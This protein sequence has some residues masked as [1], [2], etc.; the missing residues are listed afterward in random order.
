LFVATFDSSLLDCIIFQLH[1]YAFSGGKIVILSPPNLK[2]HLPL[3]P[4]SKISLIMTH[5]PNTNQPRPLL[6]VRVTLP[7]RAT[8]KNRQR[9]RLV[10]IPRRAGLVA[11][12]TRQ[13]RLP[14]P[15]RVLGI[16]R[17][18]AMG[19]STPRLQAPPPHIKRAVPNPRMRGMHLSTTPDVRV[20]K[21]KRR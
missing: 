20:G 18:R 17:A 9:P 4:L 10:P 5:R 1:Q 12:A 16:P 14:S 11:C 7:L 15:A 13:S 8:H 6:L 2:R 21:R 3:T 19:V